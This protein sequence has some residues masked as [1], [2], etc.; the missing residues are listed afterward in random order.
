MGV[1]NRMYTGRHVAL[2]FVRV[3]LVLPVIRMSQWDSLQQLD[4]VY[5][6]KLDELYSHDRFPMDV[7]HYLSSWIESQNWYG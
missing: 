7:R 2:V 4:S 6:N 1:E 3:S 5:M